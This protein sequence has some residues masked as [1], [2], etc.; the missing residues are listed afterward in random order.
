MGKFLL[1]TSSQKL[2]TN[3]G[4][5]TEA[6]IADKTRAYQ[7][8]VARQKEAAALLR[9][10]PSSDSAIVCYDDATMALKIAA[11]DM[12]VVKATMRVRHAMDAQIVAA[13]KEDKEQYAVSTQALSEAEDFLNSERMVLDSL[14][15][16][17][18]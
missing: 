10:S 13:M 11:L 17:L 3:M 6:I 4:E 15:T 1:L 9:D 12:R 5:V 14:R 2:T 8:A 7:D 18:L 16:Q